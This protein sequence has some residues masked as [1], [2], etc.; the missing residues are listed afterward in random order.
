MPHYDAIDKT[1]LDAKNRT[2]YGP[3]M[4]IELTPAIVR[5]RATRAHVSINQL[6][7][8][9]KV[10][11]STFWRWAQGKSSPHPVTLQKLEDA[12]S[13]IEHERTGIPVPHQHGG[14]E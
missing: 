13:Q 14:G 9:A 4:N 1:H 10:Q 12:L 8:R 7:D 6:M 11:N 5:D 3:T 2:G